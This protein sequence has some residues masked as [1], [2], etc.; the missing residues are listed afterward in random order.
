MRSI[1][2]QTAAAAFALGATLGACA[3]AAG[4]DTYPTKPIRLIVA[5]VPGSPPD[6]VARIISDRLAA[7]LGQPVIIENRP[8]AIGT[9][10]LSAVARSSPDGY[11]IGMLSMPW[12]V[13]PS[14]L[15][16]MPYDTL[17]DLV[18]IN[19]LIWQ[20]SLLTVRNG[21]PW[22]SLAELVAAAKAK[23]GR[24]TYASA[25]NGTPA[26]L[27][28]EL[29]KRHAGVD[30]Y[31]V[32]FKGG[33]AAFTAFVGEQVDLY[34]GVQSTVAGP[35]KA[36]KIRALATVAPSRLAMFP[37]VPTM[38]ELGFA[39]F[40]LRDW[41]GVIAPAGTAKEIIARLADELGKLLAQP[42]VQERFAALGM[43]PVLDSNP[44]AF[45]ALIRSEIA[46]WM[47]VVREAGIRAD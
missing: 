21:A 43:E 27:A 6:V 31:H 39:G 5:T 8:G 14:L 11:T 38:T 33:P 34:F 40:A 12:I 36:G 44:E 3:V 18:P 45:G 46:K 10:G 23:P 13:A 20:S 17:R 1:I 32:P 26:H 30:L 35:I 37:D 16:Q 15:P 22:Q 2:R 24:L 47:K 29:F 41:Y 4:S 28:G 42:E 25:G 19:Q 7:G 9:I